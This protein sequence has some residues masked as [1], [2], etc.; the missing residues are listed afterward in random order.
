MSPE[1]E[2]QLIENFP[3][4]YQEYYMDMQDTCMCWGFECP[5]EWFDVIF[6]L[7]KELSKISKDEN[8]KI[9]ANQVKEKFGQLRFY[10]TVGECNTYSDKI[11]DLI[12]ECII[13]AE[14]EIS[15]IKY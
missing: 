7:S 4:I 13:K 15:K 11:Y 3:D 2:K 5:D 6:K 8:I 10:Y 14:I 9:I 12:D 1:K